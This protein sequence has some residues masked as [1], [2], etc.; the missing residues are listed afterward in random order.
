MEILA[1]GPGVDRL[2][3][4]QF[5]EAVVNADVHRRPTGDPFWNRLPGFCFRC[6]GIAPSDSLSKLHFIDFTLANPELP[7]RDLPESS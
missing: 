7:S 1:V 5:T 2:D 3:H 4:C 6:Q